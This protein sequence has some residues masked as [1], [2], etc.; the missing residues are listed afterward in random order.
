MDLS[1]IIGSSGLAGVAYLIFLV[2]RFTQKTESFFSAT[3][4]SLKEIKN[5]MDK[6]SEDFRKD[7]RDI[8]SDISDIKERLIFIEAI[9]F[10][11][12][13]APEPANTHSE[14]MKKY[15]EKKKIESRE[16]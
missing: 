2:G 9:M 10:F 5:T 4:E 3:K 14:R 16:K 7:V 13:V 1:L 12:G 6:N 8:K 11:S 15:W